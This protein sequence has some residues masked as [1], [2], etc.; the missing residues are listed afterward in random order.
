[1]QI[2]KLNELGVVSIGRTGVTN[3][4]GI[5]IRAYFMLLRGNLASGINR[6]GGPIE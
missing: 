6:R 1:M 4:A 5:D 2:Q 3:K